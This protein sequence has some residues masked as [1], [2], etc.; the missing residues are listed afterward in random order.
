MNLFG[1]FRDRTGRPGTTRESRLRI[2]EHV[3]AWKDP[4]FWGEGGQ[5]VPRLYE[6]D[7]LPL[8]PDP[9][10]RA[11][12]VLLVLRAMEYRP[13]SG[14]P[15]FLLV[16]SAVAPARATPASAGTPSTNGRSPCPTEP[17]D[18]ALKKVTCSD[19]D[20]GRR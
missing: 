2:L 5:A 10:T 15:A 1:P 16:P 7:L 6:P 8:V 19:V 3:N 17:R 4:A 14:G 11:R 12:R 13:D 9:L 20:Q 18:I